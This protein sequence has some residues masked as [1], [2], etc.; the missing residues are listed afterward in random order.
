LTLKESGIVHGKYLTSFRGHDATQRLRIQP[1]LYTELFAKGDLFLPVSNHLMQRIVDLGC[2]PEKVQVLHSGIQCRHLP[3]IQRHVPEQGPVRIATVARLVEMKGVEYAVRAVA[4][5]IARGY[6]LEYHIAG[7]GPLREQLQALAKQLCVA[8]SVHFLGWRSHKQVL[9]LLDQAQILMAPSV[10]A[11]NGETEGI[12]NIVK[13]AMALGLPV[14][15]TLHAGIP[16]LVDDGKT[17]VLVP[18]R[19]AVALADKTAWLLDNPDRWPALT[20]SARSKVLAEFDADA[21]NQQLIALYQ[22]T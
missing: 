7:D 6:Q 2:N 19:D 3:F 17:G 13:E 18:E 5:L 9:Q 14:V 12:P 10:T 8:E 21:L 20:L 16:E 15:S 11:A 22:T 1:G 4:K